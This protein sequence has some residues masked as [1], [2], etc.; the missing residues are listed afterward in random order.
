MHVDFESHDAQFTQARL[1]GFE[2]LEHAR[3]CAAR[4]GWRTRS[5]VT[6]PS[7]S[8]ATYFGIVDADVEV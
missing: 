4:F 5:V 3:H 8:L 1:N 7:Y 6:G 2:A